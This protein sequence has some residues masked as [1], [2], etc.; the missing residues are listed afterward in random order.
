[1]DIVPYTI[2]EA[3]KSI[4][5]GCVG[6]LSREVTSMQRDVQDVESN[7][8]RLGRRLDE[9]IES[10]KKW[11]ASV[12]SRLDKITHLLETLS[13]NK[14]QRMGEEKEDIWKDIFTKS[15]PPSLSLE[16]SDD[17]PLSLEMSPVKSPSRNKKRNSLSPLSLELSDD[18]PVSLEMSP[19]VSSLSKR[20]KRN[21]K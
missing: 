14:E 5:T 17:E 6:N 15:V 1:M 13:S 9:F 2:D 19:P 20:K 10:D 21:R 8:L 4:V 18:E 11:K 3:L 7:S 16:M 12:D